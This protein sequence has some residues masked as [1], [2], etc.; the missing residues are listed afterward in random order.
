M[1]R[2][3]SVIFSMIC[4][5][6]TAG[7]CF[8]D[9]PTES[10]YQK[11][12]VFFATDRQVRIREKRNK[13]S[14]GDQ[15]VG[16][17]RQ[18]VLGVE[19]RKTKIPPELQKGVDWRKSFELEIFG[20]KYDPKGMKWRTFSGVTYGHLFK[21]KER[22]SYYSQIETCLS[23]C[24]EREVVLFI[25]GCCVDHAQASRQASNIQKWYRRPVILYD[26]GSKSRE[27]IQSLKAYP[28]TEKRFESFV[29]D[30]KDHFPD[31]KLTV[32]AY[33]VGTNILK[34]FCL[35]LDSES[36]PL[37]ERVILLRADTNV[38]ELEKAMPKIVGA[39]KKPVQIMASSNDTQMK[40]SRLL[41]NVIVFPMQL[42]AQKGPRGGETE[43]WLEKDLSGV[44]LIDI[45][46][47]NLNHD[48]PYQ[49]ISLTGKKALTA[50]DIG[51]YSVAQGSN[52]V[53]FVKRK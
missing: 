50:G 32:I 36:N 41:R 51:P 22:K 18:L 15:S 17:D 29:L 39:S 26:W 13:Y 20:D 46:S 53:Y 5:S 6:C 31:T 28:E 10:I 43:A 21:W 35:N 49:F 3:I 34:D 38:K 40:A 27:Y 12:P 7:I 47:L 8:A 42:L 37:F 14:Y 2:F 4:F 19:N 16:A 33:S 23:T 52:N 9:E 25:H 48:I 45:S 24:P 30:I 11:L 1:P 44:E